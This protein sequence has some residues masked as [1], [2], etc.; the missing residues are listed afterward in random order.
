M[1]VTFSFPFFFLSGLSWKF[2]WSV[3]LVKSSFQITML[4][5]TAWGSA[6]GF[7]K[8]LITWAAAKLSHFTK[9]WFSKPWRNIVLKAVYSKSTW[10][11][12]KSLPRWKHS[13]NF[14]SAVGWGQKWVS[15]ANRNSLLCRTT[16][17]DIVVGGMKRGK[18]RFFFFNSLNFRLKISPP[19]LLFCTPCQFVRGVFAQ[20]HGLKQE[21]IGQ[22]PWHLTGALGLPTPRR[23]PLPPILLRTHFA[24]STQTYSQSLLRNHLKFYWLTLQLQVSS[25]DSRASVLETCKI[26]T[27]LLSA[28]RF[29]LASLHDVP[30]QRHAFVPGKESGKSIQPLAC[31]NFQI[32]SWSGV[33]Q[34]NCKWNR[35]ED[36]LLRCAA[37]PVP[38]IRE[39][40]FMFFSWRCGKEWYSPCPE[41]LCYLYF[42]NFLLWKCSNLHKRCQKSFE[43]PHL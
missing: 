21:K 3:S 12:H 8:V 26:L 14:E 42:L 7:V 35:A 10:K 38:G 33:P 29:S 28:R 22:W 20:Q 30:E 39:Q 40:S 16:I 4:L 1:G 43:N 19:L 41:F 13:Q 32:G 37:L 27:L 6:D 15:W 18:G 31:R 11:H 36:I 2:L 17:R 23:A 9:T 25:K 24:W 5:V 34:R